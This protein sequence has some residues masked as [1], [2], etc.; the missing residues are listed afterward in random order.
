[1]TKSNEGRVTMIMQT[2][3]ELSNP[4]LCR[5]DP[6]SRCLPAHRRRS[7]LDRWHGGGEYHRGG[8]D[9]GS[10]A[11]WRHGQAVVRVVNE[12]ISRWRRFV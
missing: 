9:T 10:R 1:M 8:G 7:V 3:I 2:I 12:P 4:R 11:S 5:Q 6:R